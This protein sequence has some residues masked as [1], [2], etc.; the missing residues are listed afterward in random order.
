MFA[1][2]EISKVLFINSKENTS[3]C[4]INIRN[5]NTELQVKAG[6]TLIAIAV[7]N[8]MVLKC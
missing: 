5:M 1:N 8:F 3:Y 2:Q 6:H 7:F 4:I